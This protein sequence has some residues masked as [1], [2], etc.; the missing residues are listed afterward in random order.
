MKII[1]QFP[2][3]LAILSGCA[4]P[5]PVWQ[6]VQ[7]KTPVAVSCL[8]GEVNAPQWNLARLVPKVEAVE[9]LKA[10]LADLELAHGYIEELEAELVACG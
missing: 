1:R 5:G 7:V 9:K 6:P 4:C 2:C 8:A 10:A 3:I